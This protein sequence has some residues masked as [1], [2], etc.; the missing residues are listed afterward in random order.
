MRKI[1]IAVLSC[2][3]GLGVAVPAAHA[4]SH[5]PKRHCHHHA[6]PHPKPKHH[7]RCHHKRRHHKPPPRHHRRPCK[8]QQRPSVTVTTR[9]TVNVTTSTTVIV[10]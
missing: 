10:Q 2:I 3:A 1:L 4:G 9:T 7:K 8:H 5:P 6:K